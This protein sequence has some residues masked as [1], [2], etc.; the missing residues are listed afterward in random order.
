MKS[1]K[2]KLIL[3][4]V[5]IL[6]ITTSMLGYFSLNRASDALLQ[7]TDKALEA[8]AVESSNHLSSK[9]ETQTLYM[10]VLAKNEIILD[11]ASW[12]K[13]VEFFQKEAE[14]S[15]FLEFAFVKTNGKAV[16]FNKEKMEMDISDR[17]YFKKAIG[18]DMAI[19]DLLMNKL[20]GEPVV[21]L[22][23]PVKRNEQVVGVLIGRKDG[24]ILSENSND[25]KYG[26][27][28]Y[29]YV[30][31][32]EGTIVG[33]EKIELV[34][35]QYN[36]I[37]DAKGNKELEELSN[38]MKNRMIKREVGVGKYFFQ[39]KERIVGF[40]PVKNTPWIL[41]V[42]IENDQVLAGINNL[43][44]G[45]ILSSIIIIILAIIITYFVS[46]NISRPI[47]N[48]TKIIERLADYDL[49]FDENDEARSYLKRKDE[50]GRISNALATMQKNFI[51]LLENTSEV[52]EQLSASSQQLTSTSEQSA[53][54]SEQIAQT[55]EEIAKGATDQAK[56]TEKGADSMVK[57]GDILDRDQENMKLLNI[58]ADEVITLKDKGL[59]VINKLVTNTKQSNIATEEI[60]EVIRNTDASA[61]EIEKASEMIRSIAEQTTQFTEDIKSIVE[62]LSKRTEDAVSTVEGLEEVAKSQN[63]SVKETEDKFK[64]ISE[65]VENTKMIIEKL[66]ESGQSMKHSKDDILDLLQG[67]SAIA[68]EN[69]ASTEEASAAV[70]EETAA[71]E[72]IA[73]SSEHLSNL[74]QELNELVLKFKI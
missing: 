48:L 70:Q 58:S 6:L 63:L 16:V 9:I 25:I 8:V 35:E 69:A 21:V 24:M 10:S 2:N 45:L 66:N 74:A 40:S 67:L 14:R 62:G 55:V 61:K 72:E 32:S 60:S 39:D 43:R 68:E 47:T 17:G 49:Q 11:D 52:S 33:H 19:S 1:L 34:N 20:T 57:M 27:T 7:E 15:G 53:T 37:E 38:I 28:S 12:E 26:D 31:N 23:A 50:I 29:A 30:I 44:N 56:D 3:T 59:D 22:A 41:A 73:N 64:G 54:A 36:P 4:F 71:I 65:A 46:G 18:G 13:K 42:A 51:S 5:I